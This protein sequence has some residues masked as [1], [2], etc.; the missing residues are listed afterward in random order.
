MEK[1]ELKSVLPRINACMNAASVT[2]VIVSSL[3]RFTGILHQIVSHGHPTRCH[4]SAER[5]ESGLMASRPYECVT[6]RLV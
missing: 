6:I 5:R 3:Q 2:P 4:K 1:L